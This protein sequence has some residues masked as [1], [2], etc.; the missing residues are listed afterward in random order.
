VVG[1]KKEDRPFCVVLGMAQDGGVPHA[2]VRAHKG[3]EDLKE[4]RLA[5]CLAVVDP[6]SGQR[7]MIEATP[8]FRDQLYRLDKIF[9]HEKRPVLDGIFLTHAH[10]G[11]YAGLI[12]L[13]YESMGTREVPVHAMPRMNHFLGTNGPW[14][15]LVRYRNIVLKPLAH[16]KKVSLNDRLFITPFLVPHRQEYSEVAGFLIE[17]PEKK[18]LFIPDIDRWE[19]WDEEGVRIEDKIRKVDVAYLDGTFFADGEIPG[20]DMSGIPHPLIRKSMERF[21][22]LPLEERN[23]VRF[24]HLNHTNPALDKEGE[25]QQEIRGR[26]FFV[27]EELERVEL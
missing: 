11:H 7:W 10:I 9:P 22:K 4:R 27:A 3:W 1:E 17:G 23:K 19:D 14:D 13:G 2:G 6:L 5:A 16:G 20:R 26:G 12:F 24:I 21:E 15:Q 18:I 25:A 8:D